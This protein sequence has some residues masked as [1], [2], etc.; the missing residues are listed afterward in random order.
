[1]VHMEVRT[2]LSS[3][4]FSPSTFARVLRVEFKRLARQAAYLP[5]HELTD[6]MG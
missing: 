1:M 3:L 2:I 5:T 4:F 6:Y